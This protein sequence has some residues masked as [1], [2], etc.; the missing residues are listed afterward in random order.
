MS[1]SIFFEVVFNFFK[2]CAPGFFLKINKV[3]EL[4]VKSLS[5][6]A[7]HCHPT[8]H[9]LA[10]QAGAILWPHS[11]HQVQNKTLTLEHLECG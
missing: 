3:R 8:L 10:V 6:L 7:D 2:D 1:S 9:G 11:A 4:E 5:E